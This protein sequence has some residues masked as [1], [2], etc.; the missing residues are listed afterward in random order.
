MGIVAVIS[1]VGRVF[2]ER[3]DGT[4]R[5]VS[6]QRIPQLFGHRT[7][8]AIHRIDDPVGKPGK[9]GKPA[10]TAG[11]AGIAETPGAANTRR[12]RGT[13]TW[14]RSK[15]RRRHWP[16]GHGRHRIRRGKSGRGRNRCRRARLSRHRCRRRLATGPEIVRNLEVRARRA[17]QL[18]GDRIIRRRHTGRCR[19]HRGQP[20]VANIVVHVGL[21][22]LA[23]HFDGRR[24]ICPLR[25]ERFG[26]SQP[27][28]PLRQGTLVDR[29]GRRDFG[30]HQ[31]P[32]VVAQRF[33]ALGR[34]T[35]FGDHRISSLTVT[36]HKVHRRVGPRSR[37]CRCQDG[38]LATLHPQRLHEHTG[39]SPQLRAVSVERVQVKSVFAAVPVVDLGRVGGQVGMLVAHQV[40]SPHVA[41]RVLGCGPALGETLSDV[42]P[43]SH[44]HPIRAAA[45]RSA[46][47]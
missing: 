34:G 5:I 37:P 38:D 47:A 8:Q 43:V 42:Q 25:R 23:N 40:A 21:Y 14:R 32:E 18:I 29:N 28:R 6:C 17:G 41:L 33:A 16:R 24:P 12:R 27:C 26:R 3:I 30:V 4:R 9:P 11:A 13:I 39:G 45:H 35:D 15:I 19:S 20:V 2:S 36:L 46:S 1:V 22:L 44:P 10:Q 31:L 7:Q